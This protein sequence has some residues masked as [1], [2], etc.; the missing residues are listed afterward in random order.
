[1]ERCT[2]ANQSVSSQLSEPQRREIA[3][4][5]TE[6]LHKVTENAQKRAQLCIKEK[7]KSLHSVTFHI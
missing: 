3:A 4:I 5:L 1:M 6:T 7:G 2:L